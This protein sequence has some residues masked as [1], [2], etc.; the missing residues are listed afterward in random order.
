MHLYK[1][2]NHISI[3]VTDLE[4]TRAFYEGKLGLKTIPRPDFGF[5]GV[6]YGLDGDLSLHIIT[7]KD[8][9]F[10][11]RQRTTFDLRQAHF[12]LWTDDCDETHDQLVGRGVHVND[13][14]ST[15]TGL[16]QLFVKDPDGN[17]VEFIGPTKAARVRRM[18]T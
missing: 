12:A 3:T 2:L 10:T 17:M 6:W 4:A 13:L 1:N 15:P 11:E 9:P 5:P 16:R 14:I 8:V 7:A 18:E